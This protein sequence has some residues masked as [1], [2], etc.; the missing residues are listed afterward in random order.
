MTI[1][2]RLRQGLERSALVVDPDP[3]VT[4]ADAVSRGKRRK[5]LANGAR[6]TAV[7]VS[8]ALIALVGSQLLRSIDDQQPATKTPSP[9]EYTSIAGSYSAKI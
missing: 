6:A 1:D 8:I 7:I 4:I 3:R 5:R 2:R 9:P